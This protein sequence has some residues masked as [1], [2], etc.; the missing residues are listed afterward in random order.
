MHE[1]LNL[2]HHKLKK[3]TKKKK[4]TSELIFKICFL[5]Q[6]GFKNERK[7]C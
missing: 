7:F 5:A 6:L 1:I 4:I 2:M 3:E